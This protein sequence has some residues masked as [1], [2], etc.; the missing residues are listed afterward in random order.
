[1]FFVC[2]DV[3]NRKI[4]QLMKV[5]IEWFYNIFV[6]G[7]DFVLLDCNNV[8]VDKGFDEFYQVV[9]ESNCLFMFVLRFF[10][11]NI[12]FCYVFDIDKDN[13]CICNVE[14]NRCNGVNDFDVQYFYFR[15][16]LR[17]Y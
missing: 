1:M 12:F 9:C 11:L 6:R 4:D 10:F 14:I 5:L 17:G 8:G 13:S 16:V 3:K 15:F 7:D 2:V